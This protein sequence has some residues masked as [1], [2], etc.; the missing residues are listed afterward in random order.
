[1]PPPRV[2]PRVVTAGELPNDRTK[3]KTGV[4]DPGFPPR[5]V[6]GDS[7]PTV[8]SRADSPSRLPGFKSPFSSPPV[9][10]TG[11]MGLEKCLSPRV[12]VRF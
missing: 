11:K 9:F 1:M 6:P 5:S 8:I 4:G 12:V 2:P 7:H 3:Q 10:A